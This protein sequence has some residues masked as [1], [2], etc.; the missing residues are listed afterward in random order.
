M[1]LCLYDAWYRDWLHC[2]V[3]CGLFYMTCSSQSMYHALLA[4]SLFHLILWQFVSTQSLSFASL[5][6]V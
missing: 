1:G 6:L 5:S 2:P 3:R 4:G